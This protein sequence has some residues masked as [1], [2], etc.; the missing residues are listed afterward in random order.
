MPAVFAQLLA[1][2][3]TEASA[4]NLSITPE[5]SMC[6]LFVNDLTSCLCLQSLL[7]CWLLR[8]LR[9]AREDT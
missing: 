1:A 7:G 3:A 9:P 5:H 8:Q 6:T 4:S 2:Q